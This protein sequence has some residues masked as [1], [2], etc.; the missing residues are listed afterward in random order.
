MLVKLN[1]DRFLD[2]ARKQNMNVY[3]VEQVIKDL[4]NK[5]FVLENLKSFVSFSY[6]ERV[7]GF[8]DWIVLESEIEEVKEI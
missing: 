8:D 3:V 6:N 5:E 4:E 7:Y 1:V 2:R